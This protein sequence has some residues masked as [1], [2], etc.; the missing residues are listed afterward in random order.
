MR[1]LVK[2]G[3]FAAGLSVL[4]LSTLAI[5]TI[6]TQIVFSDATH[7]SS[8]VESR[9]Q[10]L[11]EEN[12]K[13]GIKLLSKTDFEHESTDL[14]A[15]IL[16]RRPSSLYKLMKSNGAYG[17]NAD[18][19]SQQANKWYIE[20]QAYGRE[21][22]IAGLVKNDP[23]AVQAGFKMFDWGFA[24]QAYDGSFFVTGDR[25]HSTSFFVEAVAHTLLFIQQ[26]PY[27]QKYA[28]QVAKYKP[29]VHRAARWMISSEVWEKG[30]RR[31]RAFTHRRYLV[32]GALGLTGKLTDDQELINYAR[33]YIEDGLSLQRSDGINP[34][35]GGYDS[36]YQMAG[37]IF[38]QRWLNYFPNDSLSQRVK[39]MIDRALRWEQKRI[40]ITGEINSIGN[41]RT[42]G[43]ERRRNGKVKLV[44]HRVVFRAF[45]YWA[46]VTGNKKWEAIARKIAQYYY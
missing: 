24:H 35:Q 40:L 14:I 16:Y 37:V 38:A 21:A 9:M 32:G 44:D 34:E 28:D 30:I 10:L 22:I 2:V 17:V 39:V 8:T 42:A 15:N 26:S 25:F 20:A 33:N 13:T 3:Y 31:N 45:A 1:F 46:S 29:L 43:Q 41:T 6:A 11:V 27:S 23:Q 7:T 19:D 4:F 18:W 5:R 12:S 36:S